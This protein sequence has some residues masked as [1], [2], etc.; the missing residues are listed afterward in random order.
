M[1]IA[2]AYDKLSLMDRQCLFLRYAEDY[3][4]ADIAKFFNSTSDG[5]ARMRHKRAVN[6]LIKLLG[7][8][9]VH[10]GEE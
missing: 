9:K 10:E 5:G 6:K 7:G 3:E 1:E 8:V 4:F 2:S